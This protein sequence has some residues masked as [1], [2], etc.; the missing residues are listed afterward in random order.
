MLQLQTLSLAG[1]KSF[2]D[3]VTINFGDGMTGVVGPNGCGKSNVLEAI[4]WVMGE[5]RGKALRGDNMEDVIFAGTS[6]RPARGL[7]EVR[8]TFTNPDNNAPAPYQNAPEIELSR[9]VTKANGST[10]RINGKTVRARD[11]QLFL[12]EAGT[13]AS[14][15]AFVNQG[16]VSA[17]INAKPEV[18]RGMIEEAAGISGLYMR[19]R[20]AELRL[21]A[22]SSNLTRVDD[23]MSGL[24]QQIETLSAQ[25]LEAT[26]YGAISDQIT[27][28]ERVIAHTEW[29]SIAVQVKD[30]QARLQETLLAKKKAEQN[31]QAH[32]QDLIITKEKLAT[33]QN[34][35]TIARAAQAS[36][37]HELIRHNER[38]DARKREIDILEGQMTG[39]DE[40]YASLQS[41][42][43]TLQDNLETLEQTKI[44]LDDKAST[45]KEQLDTAD[46]DVIASQSLY[47]EALETLENLRKEEQNYTADIRARTNEKTR[48]EKRLEDV[49]LELERVD[50]QLQQQSG[51]D[52]FQSTADLESIE[53]ALKLIET[54]RSKAVS[55]TTAID[56]EEK[57]VSEQM[58]ALRPEKTRC[59][60][61]LSALEAEHTILQKNLSGSLHS[62]IDDLKIDARYDRAVAVV[63]GE[64]ADASKNSDTSIY[65]DECNADV[66]PLPGKLEPL[67]KYVRNADK[68]SKLLS[69]VAVA[70]NDQDA[71]QASRTLKAG[72]M[73]VTLDG[74]LWRWDGLRITPDYTPKAA[75]KL[76]NQSRCV[77]LEKQIKK[78]GVSIQDFY[79]LE[80]QL[81]E[82]SKKLSQARQE[83]SAE[84]NE[85]LQE[86]QELNGKRRNI[87]QK[88]AAKNI[89]LSGLRTKLTSLDDE[90]LRLKGALQEALRSI[91]NFEHKDF[92]ASL[93]RAHAQKNEAFNDLNSVKIKAQELSQN[94]VLISRDKDNNI[95][96]IDRAKQELAKTKEQNNQR[97]EK[98]QKLSDDL[99]KLTLDIESLVSRINELE[100]LLSTQKDAAQNVENRYNALQDTLRDQESIAQNKQR[101]ARNTYEAWVNAAGK[102]ETLTIQYKELRDDIIERF[103]VDDPSA[104]SLNLEAPEGALQDWIKTRIQL[105]ANRE[106]MGAINMKAPEEYQ[107]AKEQFDTL[108]RERIDLAQAIKELSSTIERINK[109]ARRRL[110]ETVE[111]VNELFNPLFTKLFGGGQANLVWVHKEDKDSKPDILN[112]GV[113]IMA[114]PTGKKLQSLS[115]LSGGE[116]A[117]TAIAL[118]LAMVKTHPAPIC[119]FD[120]IDAALDESNV[121]RVS[122]ALA[123]LSAESNA[124]IVIVSHH[125]LMMAR[126]DRLF[127]VTMAERGISKL[128]SVD[129]N[130]Q[131]ELFEGFEDNDGATQESA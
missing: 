4:R 5:S 67:S 106:A 102:L 87:E 84:K 125:R 38:L 14:S 35:L 1:F 66:P 104:L 21:N 29:Q 12:N 3:P 61:E 64:A 18:R 98:K 122:Q 52:Q 112:A 116:Q 54:R 43:Q 28:L 49:T 71:I 44:E 105:V 6:L 15:P 27:N 126:M 22:A 10:F 69:F 50:K 19:R 130:K 62:I 83:L 82:Q 20:E 30:T 63:L 51:A 56:L 111:Q 95:R 57:N 78:L 118:I 73:V 60:K 101:Q 92:Y 33:A 120:E 96:D 129:L 103:D 13:G 59:E 80:Y 11:V 41:D 23:I 107:T 86:E 9:T 109:D 24:T 65:W 75:T 124:R 55:R 97:S 53:N 128:V 7:A 16:Q 76:A 114:Q 85:W 68:L 32:E 119:V 40:H 36:S 117:L 42:I 46:K 100:A 47:D 26:R 127:G 94:I 37:E 2:A 93:E 74:A 34:E 123:D 88:I 79:A 48:L 8:L 39:F 121:D 110:T 91:E 90:S 81:K 115:L 58:D 72:Q 108:D 99:S 77:E 131:P 25:A 45:L 89:E 70:H 17:L 31:S 113:D